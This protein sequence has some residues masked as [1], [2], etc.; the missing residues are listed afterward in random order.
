MD[1]KE[2]VVVVVIILV[3]AAILITSGIFY[4]N[5]VFSDFGVTGRIV[6][7]NPQ[8]SEEDKGNTNLDGSNG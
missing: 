2:L 3:L 8:I 7:Q 1:K 6:Q 5:M 4:F